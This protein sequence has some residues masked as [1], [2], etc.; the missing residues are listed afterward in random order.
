MCAQ[1]GDPLSDE[2]DESL[3]S[4][5][6]LGIADVDDINKVTMDNLAIFSVN[7][8]C[9]KQKMTSFE[10]PAKMPQCTGEKCICA[11]FWLANRVRHSVV[12]L[13]E[14]ALTCMLSS[15]DRARPTST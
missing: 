7:H 12:S 6:A 15:L 11:W 5:C 14:S 3:L 9:V 1:S 4:G 13:H 2:I 10:V 8:E